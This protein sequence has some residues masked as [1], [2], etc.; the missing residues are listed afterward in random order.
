MRRN[1]QLILVVCALAL[2]LGCAATEATQTQTVNEDPQTAV[3]ICMI[4]LVATDFGADRSVE[5]SI[6]YEYDGENNLLTSEQDHDGNGTADMLYRYAYDANGNLLMEE[7][8]DGEGNP[9]R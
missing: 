1:S 6:S 9:A 7:K 8:T 2:S 3:P 5:H 4:N